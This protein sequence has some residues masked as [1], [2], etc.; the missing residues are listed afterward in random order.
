[1]SEVVQDVI[2]RLKDMID[3]NAYI[4]SQLTQMNVARDVKCVLMYYVLLGTMDSVNYAVLYIAKLATD[5]AR[6]ALSRIVM[7]DNDL[8]VIDEIVNRG[9]YDPGQAQQAKEVLQIERSKIVETYQNIVSQ[10]DYTELR[11][12]LL[13]KLQ[14]MINTFVETC[15]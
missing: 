5:V 11:D 9:W 4:L 8:Q 14:E 13:Q 7:I 15:G 2:Q 12:Y 10:A 3:N 1:M 6:S